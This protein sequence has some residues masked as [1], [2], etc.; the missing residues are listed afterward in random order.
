MSSNVYKYCTSGSGVS[1]TASDSFMSPVPNFDLA[2]YLYVSLFSMLTY[3]RLL[4]R[5]CLKKADLLLIPCLVLL[6]CAQLN[7][8]YVVTCPSIHTTATPERHQVQQQGPAP[9]RVQ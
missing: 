9:L 8:A 6:H 4:S 2:S 1:V 7:T 3:T 5:S